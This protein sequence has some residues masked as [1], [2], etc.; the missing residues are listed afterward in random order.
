MISSDDQKRVLT[1]IYE[2]LAPGGRFI[3][4]LHNP[5]VR[6]RSVDGQ[7]RLDGT[8]PGVDPQTT[9]FLWS[10]STYDQAKNIVEDLQFYEHYD[11]RGML[12]KKSML[13]IRFAL[14]QRAEFETLAEASGFQIR[15]FYGD[16]TYAPFQ[17][18]TSPYMI[19]VLGK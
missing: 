15:S 4:T 13:S 2:H 18:E 16:Y 7:L 5:S 17:E 12:Q 10:V 3:C 11:Q 8:Y 1:R 19:W 9:L 6:L 14:L